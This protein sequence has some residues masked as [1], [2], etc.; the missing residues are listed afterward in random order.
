MKRLCQALNPLLVDEADA[1]A[2]NPDDDPEVLRDLHNV[3][4]L[5]NLIGGTTDDA[6]LASSSGVG[7]QPTAIEVDVVTH[8]AAYKTAIAFLSSGGARRI[9]HT[10]PPLVFGCLALARR[11]L[12]L[13]RLPVAKKVF[14]M[15][16]EV[17]TGLAATNTEL[18]LR[19]FV[20]AALAASGASGFSFDLFSQGAL[21]L[22]RAGWPLL[23]T[24]AL[25]FSSVYFI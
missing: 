15:V 23:L 19:L 1:P 14:L 17:C 7:A 21:L 20:H 13:E 3:A 10:F 22:R 8:L 16:H 2:G 11:A 12:A 6:A 18:A 9:C 4:R 25:V 5:I 24:H